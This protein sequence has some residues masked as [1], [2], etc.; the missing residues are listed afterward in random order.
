[1]AGL[2]FLLASGFWLLDSYRI[3]IQNSVG[4]VALRMLGYTASFWGLEYEDLLR[5]SYQHFR[6]FQGVTHAPSLE[7][8]S[9][10]CHGSHTACLRPANRFQAA[11][12]RRGKDRI[13][14]AENNSCY[15]CECHAGMVRP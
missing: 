10:S 5:A 15:S 2:S 12:G 11:T 7:F 8:G 4:E 14:R 6:L 1:M 9:L 3:L 13:G